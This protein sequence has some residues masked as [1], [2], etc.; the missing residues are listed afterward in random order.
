MAHLVHLT[1]GA[2]PQRTPSSDS[3]FCH[4]PELVA[5]HWKDGVDSGHLP[6]HDVGKMCHHQHH[7]APDQLPVLLWEMAPKFSKFLLTQEVVLV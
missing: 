1:G 3:Q 7:P 5:L 6:G 4:I 2:E